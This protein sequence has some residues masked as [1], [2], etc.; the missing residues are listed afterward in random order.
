MQREYEQGF[1]DALALAEYYLVKEG[2]WNE[3]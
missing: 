1:L 3:Q 2:L